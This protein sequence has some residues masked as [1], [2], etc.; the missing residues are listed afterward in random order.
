MYG[1]DQDLH[2][3]AILVGL[4]GLVELWAP[5]SFIGV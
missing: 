4:G 1:P 5:Y 3:V 2:I